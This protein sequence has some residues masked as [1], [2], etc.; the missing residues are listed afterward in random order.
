[1]LIDGGISTTVQYISNTTPIPKNKYDIALSTALAGEMLGMKQIFLDAGSG[2]K[3]CVSKEMISAVSSAVEVPV[4]VGG[5]I[6]TGEQASM[7]VKAGADV[8]VVG[9]A[10]ESNPTLIF[11]IAKALGK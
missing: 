11:E 10:I 4:I 9:N 8:V 6:R 3:Y 2:A 1:M 7:A 5:G